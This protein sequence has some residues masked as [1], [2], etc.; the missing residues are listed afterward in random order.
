MIQTFHRTLENH[1]IERQHSDANTLQI[2]VADLVRA[3]LATWLDGDA[4]VAAT[5]EAFQKAAA[6]TGP[7]ASM[8]APQHT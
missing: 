1:S 7:P 3:L 4:A 8:T 6:V 5:I 2:P